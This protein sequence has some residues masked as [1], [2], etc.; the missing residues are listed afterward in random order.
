M[1]SLELARITGLVDRL[2]LQIKGSEKIYNNLFIDINYKKMASRFLRPGYIINLFNNKW[3]KYAMYY[4][5]LC[6]SGISGI[7]NLVEPYRSY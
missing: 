6:I 5:L 1:N 2:A 3:I 7:P 4:L